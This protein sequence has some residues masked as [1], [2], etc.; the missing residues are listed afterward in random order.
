MNIVFESIGGSGAF[1][2]NNKRKDKNLS[3][4]RVTFYFSF[5]LTHSSSDNYCQ[6][7][8]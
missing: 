6:L 2:W 8:A 1:F 3:F 5:S 7:W 4:K